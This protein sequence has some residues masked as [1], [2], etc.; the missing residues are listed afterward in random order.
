MV[1]RFWGRTA[2]PAVLPGLFSGQAFAQLSQEARRAVADG[3]DALGF[4]QIPF[5]GVW[6]R[7]ALETFRATGREGRSFDQLRL[8]GFGRVGFAQVD[9][10]A[11]A[12]VV[13]KGNPRYD[14]S[15]DGKLDVAE[16][17]AAVFDLI[18]SKFRTKPTVDSDVRHALG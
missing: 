17:R 16:F 2:L 15:K 12:P 4:N 10:T 9:R 6:L 5:I 11:L 3:F 7:S 14:L 18:H 13:A 1:Y 8:V